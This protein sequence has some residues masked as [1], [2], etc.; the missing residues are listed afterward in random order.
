[1]PCPSEA[2]YETISL[3]VM[4]PLSTLTLAGLLVRLWREAKTT[5]AW[6]RARAEARGALIA[7]ASEI[8]E[9]AWNICQ[10]SSDHGLDSAVGSTCAQESYRG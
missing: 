5:H 4:V 10:A 3:T 8:A 1:M 7:A 9:G 6:I 2:L